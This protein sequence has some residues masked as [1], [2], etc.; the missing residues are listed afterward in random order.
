LAWLV[1]L[2]LGLL[3]PSSASADGETYEEI[4]KRLKTLGI[5]D[6]LSADI[7]RAIARSVA[8][9]EGTYDQVSRELGSQ[10]YA[11][12]TRALMALA[13]RHCGLKEGVEAGRRRLD[14]LLKH[15]PQ[16]LTHGTYEAG[17]LGLLLLADTRP[18]DTAHELHGLLT[19]GASAG[20]WGYACE[21]PST[22]NL[23]TSQFA[24]LGLWSG[25]RLGVPHQPDAWLPHLKYLIR[26]QV[27]DGSWAY[28]SPGAGLAVG[29]YPT[30]TF[31][32]LADLVLAESALVLHLR[33]DPV[34]RAHTIVARHR[35]LAALRRHAAWVLGTLPDANLLAGRPTVYDAYQLY[36]LEK[37][38]LFVGVE[39]IAGR[40]WY[41][42]LA[43][44]LAR[45][46]QA[47]GSWNGGRLS[48]AQGG[49]AG[50]AIGDAFSLLVLLRASET[51]R[52]VTPRRLDPPPTTTPSMPT[53]APK[54]PKPDDAPVPGLPFA[55]AMLARLAQ[56]LEVLEA[57]H[58][59]QSLELLD[60]MRRTWRAYQPDGKPLSDAHGAWC[61]QA[62]DLL[63]QVAFDRRERQ[64]K[65][66][67]H[68]VAL[69]LEATA[70][71][72][73]L[74]RSV[75][76]PLLAALARQEANETWSATALHGWRSTALESLRRVDRSLLLGW[77][78][79]RGYGEGAVDWRETS[80]ALV[81]AAGLAT[82][83]GPG[84]R[85]ALTSA[86]RRAVLEAAFVRME[87]VLKRRLPGAAWAGPLEQD[88]RLLVDQ[89][90]PGALAGR[91]V[92]PTPGIARA[93]KALL[94]WWEEH[95]VPDHEIWTGN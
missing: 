51:Y 42:E 18:H 68:A 27:D 94:D 44:S 39:S 87:P 37:V 4:E 78:S 40:L 74:D 14:H 79:G 16:K 69:G 11:A 36:A 60:F 54:P 26:A 15:H 10:A 90:L 34:L 49:D 7:Q 59:G 73:D 85:G 22:G 33:G 67:I 25:E 72:G 81:F 71:L 46:Q 45:T 91:A 52:P 86:E 83:P 80:Q 66:R 1:V 24:C 64:L 5:A 41:H 29:S 76:P 19:K 55:Q 63:L 58:L 93:G 20:M 89:H 95:R 50:S 32:G 84:G 77:L 43:R 57:E 3:A 47:N 28:F 12:G 61:R 2:A 82:P 88:L 65:A 38:S 21:Y 56:N 6:D 30:G 17:I 48:W 8:R 31:M 70:L 62:V 75:A 23:S 92:H 9:I 53:P 13:L 35:G